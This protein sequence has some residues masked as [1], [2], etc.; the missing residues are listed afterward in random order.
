MVD[1]PGARALLGGHVV[2]RANKG[3]RARDGEVRHLDAR[4]AEVEDLHDAVGHQNVRRLQVAVH[5]PLGVRRFESLTNLRRDVERAI[6]E[7]PIVAT[8]EAMIELLELME[9]AAAYKSTVLISGETGTGK[10]VLARAVHAQSPRRG[11]K[12]LLLRRRQ[13]QLLV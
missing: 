10:E 12:L 1:R 4:D 13:R 9:R 6:G 5:D 8:S 3:I 11:E 2:E 7:R